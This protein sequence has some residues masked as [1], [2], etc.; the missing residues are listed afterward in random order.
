MPMASTRTSFWTDP[1]TWIMLSLAFGSGEQDTGYDLPAGSIIFPWE[2][3]VIVD[4]LDS[5]ITLEV[6]L[7]SSEGGGDA[8]GFL[9]AVSVATAGYVQPAFTATAGTNNNYVS[10]CTYGAYF[11][12][13][14][15]GAV[16]AGAVSGTVTN[17]ISNLAATA[18]T[19][20]VNVDTHAVTGAPALTGITTAA[21]SAATCAMPYNGMPFLKAH[22]G[23][24]TAKSIT[25]TCSG[26]SDSFLGRL[27]LRTRVLPT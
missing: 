11:S 12:K 3:Y 10:A 25:Y 22:V 24:G 15:N 4:T 17:S 1:G 6:G 16:T 8:D 13:G 21:L 2:M 18:G 23:D 26:G 5:G 7:L 9:D 27:V 19:L 20:A 14:K